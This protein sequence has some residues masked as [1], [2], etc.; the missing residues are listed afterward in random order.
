M[1]VLAPVLEV[2]NNHPYLS[3]ASVIIGCAAFVRLARRPSHP[4]LPPGP[5][6]YPIVGNLFDLYSTQVWK[7][8]SAWGKQYGRFAS[9]QPSHNSYSDADVDFLDIVYFTRAHRTRQRL[10]SGHNSTQLV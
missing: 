2:V 1:E 8:Y 5:R 6:G 9:T 10:G 3:L 4:R 7:Q